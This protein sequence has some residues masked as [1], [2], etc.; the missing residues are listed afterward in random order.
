MVELL[1]P[2]GPGRGGGIASQRGRCPLRWPPALPL[3]PMPM[4]GGAGK[5][6]W[7][8]QDPGQLQVRRSAPLPSAGSVWLV[9]SRRPCLTSC[10][11]RP[12][13][14]LLVKG[15]L[16]QAG[17]P[18]RGPGCPERPRRPALPCSALQG[19][20]RRGHRS[21]F[22]APPARAPGDKT[23]LLGGDSASQPMWGRPGFALPWPW[24][25]GQPGRR[26]G[27]PEWQQA[28]GSTSSSG[29][30]AQ[31]GHPWG[32]L[33]PG[34]SGHSVSLSHSV[35]S[36]GQWEAAVPI[37]ERGSEEGEAGGRG[38]GWGEWRPWGRE[39]WTPL[40]LPA[41]G[42]RSPAGSPEGGQ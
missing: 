39:A 36:S 35:S 38:W 26:D 24:A 40:E 21:G 16:G 2:A 37:S 20:E 5:A 12:P 11:Q 18:G 22:W 13:L 17:R 33:Q 28:C 8:P 10:P 19:R 34:L 23:A 41:L 3:L 27:I 1:E 4:L 15:V 29:E 32:P 42:W 30:R 7:P 25:L 9:E 6:L 31:A 14:H